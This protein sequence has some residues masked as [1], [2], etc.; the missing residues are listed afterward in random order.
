M[1]TTARF[2]CLLSL[3]FIGL[4]CSGGTPAATE[5]E[6][7]GMPQRVAQRVHDVQTN[8]RLKNLGL[9]YKM[10]AI[11]GRTPKSFDDLLEHTE[12]QPGMFQSARDKKEFEVVWGVNLNNIQDSTTTL[13]A[14]EK[15]ADPNGG[16]C[17]LMADCSTAQYLNKEEFDKAPRAKGR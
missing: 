11:G 9:T 13:L 1:K 15:T 16:R 14:W 6:E 12:K 17:V 4:G 3:P 2:L 10:A 7:Q 5:K 8:A